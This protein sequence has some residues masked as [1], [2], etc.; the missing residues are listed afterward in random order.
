MLLNEFN[1]LYVHIPKAAGQSIENFFLTELNK[2]RKENGKDHLLRF[3]NDSAKG[4]ERLAH[5]TASDYVNYNYLT[6]DEFNKLYKFSIVRNPWT[7]MISF[8]KYLGF[9]TLISFNDFITRFL[10]YYF[11]NQH[12]FFRP[13]VDFIYEEN[14][15]ILDF[16]GK[17]EQLND[18]F[19]VVA[20]H[21]NLNFESL[22]KNNHSIE[23]GLISRKSFNLIKKHPS[24]LKNFKLS[25][26]NKS[27]YKQLYNS[28]SR[29]IVEKLY[30]KDIDLLKYTF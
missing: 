20:N 25:P 2:T 12:W 6:K 17:L 16:V 10:P 1:A 26:N 22:P 24:I 29:N 7:R 19:K 30:E 13:Q 15:M 3:N 18:D 8:Y 14:T 11:E 5:L 4:P 27:N 21:L 23:K 28:S 9:S